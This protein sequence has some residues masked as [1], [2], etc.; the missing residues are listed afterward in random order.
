[1]VG[2][3]IGEEVALLNKGSLVSR[4]TREEVANVDAC[5][6]GVRRVRARVVDG[7]MTER[8]MVYGVIG[9]VEEG[10]S[11]IRRIS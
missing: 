9:W 1:V 5:R 4:V 3:E 6:R 11:W 8:D 7:R 2:R 10:S